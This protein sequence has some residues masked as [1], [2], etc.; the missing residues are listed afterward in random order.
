MPDQPVGER[1]KKSSKKRRSK[2][3]FLRSRMWFY[4]F[5]S[6]L[7]NDRGTIPPNIGNNIMI[8][9]N[10]YITKNSLSSLITIPEFSTEM[11]LAWTTDLLA[12]VKDK[13]PG[14]ISYARITAFLQSLVRSDYRQMQ[15]GILLLLDASRSCLS[16][17]SAR[18]LLQIT[19]VRS[20]IYGY[21]N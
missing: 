1:L 8:T 11:P 15:L 6:M 7:F 4:T 12:A 5:T 17:S 20:N 16:T 2:E 14:I 19:L 13:V 9:N 3:K 21:N 10:L 18:Q